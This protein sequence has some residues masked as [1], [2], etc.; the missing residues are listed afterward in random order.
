MEENA[1]K[2]TYSCNSTYFILDVTA[3]N[4]LENLKTVK[5]AFG[6]KV[7]MLD[8]QYCRVKKI[9]KNSAKH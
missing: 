1:I 7:V 3:I 2:I 5:W 6:D 9:I 8:V 4:K